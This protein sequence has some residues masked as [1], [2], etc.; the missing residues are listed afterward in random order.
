MSDDNDEDVVAIEGVPSAPADAERD[1]GP[2]YHREIN[3]ST[4]KLF[5]KAASSLKSQLD[6]GGDDDGMEPAIPPP[7]DQPAAAAAAPPPGQ[8]MGSQAASSP[9]PAAAAPAPDRRALDLDVR[10]QGIS[11][12]EAELDARAK[13][14]ESL[15]GLRERY[16]E[17]GGGEVIREL[18][19][20]WTGASTDDELREEVADLVSDLS[21]SALGVQAPE[22]LRTRNDAKRALRQV[23]SYKADLARREA[24]LAK[25][26]EADRQA[27]SERQVA[28]AIGAQLASNAATYPHLMVEDNPHDIVWQ[29]LKTKAASEPTWSP[30][31][32]EAAKIANDHYKAA[33]EAQ[34]K[35]LSRL[36]IP[37]TQT[38][39]VEAQHQGRGHQVQT[40]RTQPPPSP[41]PANAPV[42]DD[43]PYDRH[44]A[45][46][47]SLS[48]LRAEM[49]KRTT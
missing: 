8:G 34:H 7:D 48:R 25:Q 18:L 30:N 15:T 6:D 11:A 1:D 28:Q 20:E 5:A 4:R 24:E 47:R 19:K 17:R 33:H 46:R 21:S 3:E 10:E 45:R 2:I 12:R 26:A 27:A 23:K 49:E 9:A 22:E 39:A 35:K 16:L 36:F 44:A 29:V 14:L 40:A 43:E 38:P 37:A 41:P 31:W 32:A 42:D 13:S